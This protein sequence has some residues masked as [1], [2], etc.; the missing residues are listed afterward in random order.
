MPRIVDK[1]V[2]QSLPLALQLLARQHIDIDGLLGKLAARAGDGSSERRLLCE[3]LEQHMTLEEK[4]FY[5]ALGRLE[6]LASFVQRMHDQHRVIRECL[7]QLLDTE[8]QA[9]TFDRAVSTLNEA[10]DLHVQDEEQRA[11][12]YAVEHLAAELDGLAVEMEA[13]REA[14]Q[15]AFGVG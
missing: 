5:P 4:V 7:Q 3:A 8:L 9:D 11:F 14:E 1:P 13:Q 6:A 15:G 12:D 2:S 10:V